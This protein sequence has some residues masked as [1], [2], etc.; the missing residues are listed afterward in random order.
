[1]E[2]DLAPCPNIETPED[3]PLSA[4]MISRVAL[5]SMSYMIGVFFGA[6]VFGIIADKYGRLNSLM[7]SIS[8]TAIVTLAGAFV[9]NYWPYFILR[10]LAGIFAQGQFSM[11]VCLSIEFVGD[12]WRLPL[13]IFIEVIHPPSSLVDFVWL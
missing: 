5:L 11:A 12:K 8:S 6:P 10:L 2:F 3:W 13:G 9:Q 1:M 7:L 4:F